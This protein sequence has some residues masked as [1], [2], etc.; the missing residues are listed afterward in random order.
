MRLGEVVNTTVMEIDTP[1]TLEERA[2]LAAELV[3]QMDAIEAA[4]E[5]EKARH[6]AAKADIEEMETER[7][8]LQ[9]IVRAKKEKRQIEV[10]IRI[11]YAANARRIYRL[12]S[13]DLVSERALEP[14]ERQ[15]AFD[16]GS[17]MRATGGN[18]PPSYERGEEP[19]AGEGTRREALASTLRPGEEPLPP[20]ADDGWGD[21]EPA[22]SLTDDDTGLIAADP[23]PVAD[24]PKRR[25][26]ADLDPVL[27]AGKPKRGRKTDDEGAD[28]G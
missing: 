6:K 1:L 16:W 7:A 21:L 14:E 9:A 27:Q 28:F 22:I 19:E 5:A 17:A 13:G 4:D 12:D 20:E 2:Q 18:A 11:D 3:A 10:E 24:P 26:R 23:E 8:R 15:R 25:G